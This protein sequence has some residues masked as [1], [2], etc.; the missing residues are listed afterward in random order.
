MSRGYK[1]PRFSWEVR[2]LKTFFLAAQS[3]IWKILSASS[4]CEARREESRA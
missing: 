3:G 1:E 4:V 2:S